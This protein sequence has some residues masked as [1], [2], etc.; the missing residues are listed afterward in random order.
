VVIG[1][2]NT[3]RFGIHDRPYTRRARQLNAL[4]SCPTRNSQRCGIAIA[5]Q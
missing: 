3:D 2:K 1:Q 5:R 4:R